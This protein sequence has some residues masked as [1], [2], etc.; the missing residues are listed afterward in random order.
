MLTLV[1]AEVKFVIRL[2]M[3][4]NSPSFYYEADQKSPLE[5]LIAPINKPRIYRQ[6]YYMGK[7]CLNV[8]G[9]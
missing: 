4:F 1:E 6:V 2:K 5:L 7:V 8:I 3:G 9:I